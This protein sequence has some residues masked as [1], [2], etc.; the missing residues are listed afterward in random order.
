MAFNWQQTGWPKATVNR[1]ALK[2]ELDAFKAALTG[3]RKFLKKPQDP[4]AVA[5]ALVA[6]TLAEGLG[7]PLVLPV[8]TVIARRCRADCRR[9]DRAPRQQEDRRLL[10]E[11]ARRLTSESC[12]TIL[13]GHLRYDR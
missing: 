6:K 2:E 8:S 11:A 7:L 1:A 12:F 13:T 9:K 4:E 5:H 10:R 3:A